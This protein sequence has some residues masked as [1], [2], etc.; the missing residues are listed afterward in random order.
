MLKNIRNVK[1]NSIT[2]GYYAGLVYKELT[3]NTD[4]TFTLK[5]AANPSTRF[6]NNKVS[7]SDWWNNNI[8][9]QDNTDKVLTRE[10]IVFYITNKDGYAHVDTQLPQK[11]EAFKNSNA[12]Q[13]ELNGHIV[14]PD[15]IP[16]YPAVRQIAFEFLSSFYE[17]YP[18]YNHQQTQYRP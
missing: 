17:A 1:I 2:N 11:Y 10:R 12:V 5:C 3:G 8:V 16:V 15:G 9:F 6:L 4:G 13:F 14:N 7:F 18:I